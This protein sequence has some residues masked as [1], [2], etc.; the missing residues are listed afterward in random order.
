MK[1]TGDPNSKGE[2]GRFR[3]WLQWNILTGNHTLFSGA[4]Q[5]GKLL[6]DQKPEKT[7]NHVRPRC[8]PPA[9]RYEI[10]IADPRL[11]LIN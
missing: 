3:E 6:G 10:I 2:R 4:K 8:K 7:C 9:H 11:A 5:D 1:G